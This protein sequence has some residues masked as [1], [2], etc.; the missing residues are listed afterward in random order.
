M[1]FNDVFFGV[2]ILA[3][4]L[5]VWFSAIGFPKVPGTVYGP[6]FFPQI[7]A[8][9]LGVCALL[10]MYNGVQAVRAG[11][12]LVEFSIWARDPLR[13]FGVLL[14]L[15]TMVVYTMLDDILG[16][17]IAGFI[18]T[19]GFMLYLGVRLWLAVLLS[20]GAVIVIWLLF[21]RVLLVPLPGGVLTPYLW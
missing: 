15:G 7:L 6:A 17:H 12:A 1:R 20:L 10:L 19:L 18:I 4:S 3:L 8:I 16:F 5:F 11:G 14:T 2:A 9:G 13:W 21:A